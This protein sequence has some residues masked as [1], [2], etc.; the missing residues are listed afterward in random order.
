MSLPRVTESARRRR[1][2]W[3]E[4]LAALRL[5]DPDIRVPT[6]NTLGNL[7]FNLRGRDLWITVYAASSLGRIGVFLRGKPGYYA[8]IWPKRKQIEAQIGAPLS[9][10]PDHDH[11]SVAV[12]IK[13]DPTN[14][15][16]WPR[17][18]RWLALRLNEFIGAFK[19]FASPEQQ[20][21]GLSE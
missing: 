7:W 21:R 4:F 5:A 3:E 20:N 1:E 8:R 9:W 16:D 17:Q 15:E 10:N 11:W 6:P 19:P 2:Y 18:H 14:R 12:S 13:G